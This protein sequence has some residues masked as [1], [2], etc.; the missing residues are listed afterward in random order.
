M[1]F[2]FYF[3]IFLFFP[4]FLFY[5]YFYFFLFFFGLSTIVV[6]RH[7]IKMIF[8]RRWSVVFDNFIIDFSKLY[9]IDDVEKG[10]VGCERWLKVYRWWSCPVSFRIF[11]LKLKRFDFFFLSFK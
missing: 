11:R 6:L 5:F 8:M 7:G 3:F 10:T 2:F 4:L 9:I 1:I